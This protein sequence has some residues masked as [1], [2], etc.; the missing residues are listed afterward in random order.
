MKMLFF[1]CFSGISGDMVLGAFIDLG[2]D[3]G[4]L[5]KELEKLKI[6][7]FRIEAETTTKY[8]IS[9]TKCHVIIEEDYAQHRHFED[10]KEIINNSTLDSAV[11]KTAVAIFTR[12]AKAEAKVHKMSID[13]VHF[14]EV[15]AIDS[16]VDIV[17]AAICY[18][19]VSPE[20]VYGTRIN[21]GKGWVKCEHGMLPVPAPATTEILC[22]S[23]FEIYSKNIDG[24]AATPTG[25]AI[26]TELATFS[27]ETPS[28][29]PEKIG[30]GFGEKDF[31]VLNALR[32]IQGRKSNASDIFVLEAN[33][34][35]MT[36]EVAGYVMERF[37]ERGALDVFYT[38][39]YMKKNRPAFLL[40]VLAKE[41]DVPIMEE[42]FLKETTT[43][44]LRKYVATR[45]CMNRKFRTLKTSLGD[46]KIKVCNYQNI[47]REAFEYEDV[48]RIAL[49]NGIPFNDVISI[50]SKEQI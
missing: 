18:H 45:S 47:Q 7:G 33:I 20:I 27:P 9:G 24:E 42:I 14:H 26:L 35:D 10:I 30:Y 50:I 41:R 5:S 32:I 34:D 4:Y 23:D 13:H 2:V 17:G 49:E 48:K 36:G 11:K 22:D 37:F 29:I 16:I 39:I 43:I 1:D 12:V 25:I 21:V 15:G 31:G 46:V 44:G 6:H 3:V 28:F 38:P 19:A 8:G 40:T